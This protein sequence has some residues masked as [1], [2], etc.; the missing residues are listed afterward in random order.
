VGALKCVG[1]L[2]LDLSRRDS[3]IHGALLRTLSHTNPS[4][5]C[6]TLTGT[7]TNTFTQRQTKEHNR[8]ENRTVHRPDPRRHLQSWERRASHP[9]STSFRLGG[10][11]LG[12]L[13][14]HLVVRLR[15]CHKWRPVRLGHL[16]P[17]A[18]E[19]GRGPCRKWPPPQ[20]NWRVRKRGA[21]VGV[22]HS[23]SAN[24]IA[25]SRAPEEL[26]FRGATSE[27]QRHKAFH[28][29]TALCDNELLFLR[30]SI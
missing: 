1:G 21:N 15:L 2:P 24:E 26:P 17:P 6:A 27:C 11:G 7:Y 3:L 12:C 10:H 16:L 18:R 19:S 28:G 23:R 20:P 13:V 22:G 5:L 25:T 30:I 9:C 14:P 4:R 29:R 8:H